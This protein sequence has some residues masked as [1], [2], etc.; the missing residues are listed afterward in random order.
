M[1]GRRSVGSRRR[2]R[3]RVHVLLVRRI[4]IRKQLIELRFG[5][6]SFAAVSRVADAEH[7][8][9]RLVH[10]DLVKIAADR[11][12]A[13]GNKVGEELC[14]VIYFVIDDRN[15]VVRRFGLKVGDK[16]AQIV[17]RHGIGAEHG[18][19][20]LDTLGQYGNEFI[21]VNAVNNPILVVHDQAVV[22]IFHFFGDETERLDAS[23]IISEAHRTEFVDRVQS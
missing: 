8:L 23:V 6:A 19:L 3:G 10:E 9:V 1:N 2:S 17:G 15:R 14:A 20:F 11:G 12:N 4:L 22:D 7:F 18:L 16:L 21:G 13:S 5:N